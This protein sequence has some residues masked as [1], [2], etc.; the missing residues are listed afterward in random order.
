MKEEEKKKHHIHG[1]ILNLNHNSF[2]NDFYYTLDKKLYLP[3]WDRIE[4][5]AFICRGVKSENKWTQCLVLSSTERCAGNKSLT[6]MSSM[7][8]GLQDIWSFSFDKINTDFFLKRTCQM[9]INE[10]ELL[11]VFIIVKHQHFTWNFFQMVTYYHMTFR[12]FVTII[13]IY[14]Q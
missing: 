11:T 9:W 6:R 13:T 4:F 7:F 5:N 10:P 14:F 1:S 2:F 8:W 12:T 3:F